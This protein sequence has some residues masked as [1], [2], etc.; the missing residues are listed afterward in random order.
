[1]SPGKQN[2]VEDAKWL[3]LT[4]LVFVALL[5]WLEDNWQFINADL[6]WV[7]WGFWLERYKVM[8]MLI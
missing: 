8:K 3:T 1:M 7:A 6:I 5:Q 4:G 2:Q